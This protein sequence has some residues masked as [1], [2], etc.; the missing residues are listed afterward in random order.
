VD[1]DG[2]ADEGRRQRG[3]TR[4]L[5]CR[6]RVLTLLAPEPNSF[7]KD[8]P[9]NKDGN[10][11]RSPIPREEFFLLEDEDGANFS[12]TGIQNGRKAV[13]V[14]AGGDGDGDPSPNPILA[15]LPRK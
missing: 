8:S 3:R 6:G 7:E 12:P 5:D 11:A 9:G 13:P 14:G 4:P 1:I 15:N 2:R 10:G